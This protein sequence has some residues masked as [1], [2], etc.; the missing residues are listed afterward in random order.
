VPHAFV[1]NKCDEPQAQ[2]SLHHLEASL[3][4]ARPFETEPVPVFLTSAKTGQGVDALAADLAATLHRAHPGISGREP[5][6]FG[7]WVRD[8]WGRVGTRM[9]DHL[10]G[11]TSWLEQCGGF[12]PAQQAFDARLRADLAGGRA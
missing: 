4:L 11:A 7:R 6:F 12:E 1:L 3:W 5:H 8:E 9:L 2:Q 10:G